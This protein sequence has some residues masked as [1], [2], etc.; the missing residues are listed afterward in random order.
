MAFKAPL[1]F[2]AGAD[3]V[4]LGFDIDANGPYGPFVPS[5]KELQGGTKVLNRK[6]VTCNGDNGSISPLFIPMAV[7][8]YPRSN[9]IR[10]AVFATS[11]PTKNRTG[12]EVSRTAQYI[13]RSDAG[14]L[15]I[16]CGRSR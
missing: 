2:L 6:Q 5:I 10:T 7:L 11:N 4:N 8:I 14:E 1:L 15:W 16:F 13:G 3:E 9:F 12:H